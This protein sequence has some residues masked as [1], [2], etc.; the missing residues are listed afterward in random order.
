MGKSKWLLEKQKAQKRVEWM[1]KN[2]LNWFQG[3]ICPGPKDVETGEIES[4][5]KTLEFYKTY[6]DQIVIQTKWMGSYMCVYMDRDI[7]KTMF[8]SRNGYT[9]DH[10]DR[11]KLLGTIKDL[12]TEIFASPWFSKVIVEGELVPWRVLGEGL[13]EREYGN[14]GRLHEDRLNY[15]TSVNL[16]DKLLKTLASDSFKN[17]LKDKEGQAQHIR[18]QYSSLEGLMKIIPDLDDYKADIE[19]YRSQFDKFGQDGEWA[20]KYFGMLKITNEEGF[21]EIPSQNGQYLAHLGLDLT[22]PELVLCLSEE[23]FEE[24]VEMA[25]GFFKDVEEKGEEGI[26]IK[27]A[28]KGLVGIPPAVK[29]RTN[30]YLQLIYGINFNS[31][32]DYYLQK[33]HTKRKWSSS[34][35]D[36]EIGYQLLQIPREK[37]HKNNKK[38]VNLLYQAID[39][40]KFVKTLDTRL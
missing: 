12:H 38:Y 32:F 16:H 28:Q 19:L 18:R 31:N 34:I 11:E 6:T 20:F 7:E 4:I 29:I 23:W 8:V 2:K 27:P 39:S 24:S 36:Y 9:M 10:I 35:K 3:T 15:L 37:L 30:K 13:I 26:V 33:R 5:R 1:V 21:E 22:E 14:Y 25:Y 40:E 17:Y